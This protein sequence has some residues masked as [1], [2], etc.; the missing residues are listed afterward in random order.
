MG[1]DPARESATCGHPVVNG[2]DLTNSAEAPSAA[3]P[4]GMPTRPA[5]TRSSTSTRSSTRRTARRTWWRLTRPCRRDLASAYTTPNYVFITP[6]LCN[7]GHDGAGTGA[8]GT[9]CANGQPGGLTSADAF[10]KIGCRR[11]SRHPRIK[12]DGLLVITFD[13]SN[14]AQVV[15]PGTATTPTTVAHHLHGCD[16]LQSGSRAR[17]SAASG[18]RQSRCSTARAWSRSWCSTATAVTRWGRCCSR[19]S[20]S[21]AAP[22]PSRTTTTRCCAASRTSSAWRTTWGMPRSRMRPSAMTG[23]S[24]GL[25]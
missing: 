24:S 8:T 23:T 4:P 5:T 1:N 18:R 10:L 14:A 12:R 15:T 22:R 2:P 16:L 9:L 19:R 3:V 11:S 7:D 21:P 25:Y 20:S 17:T 13:E 6:N